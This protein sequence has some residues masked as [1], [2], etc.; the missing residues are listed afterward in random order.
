M[1]QGE[2]IDQETRLR[3]IALSLALELD[4]SLEPDPIV[5]IEHLA[6]EACRD[7]ASARGGIRDLREALREALQ[8]ASTAA[9][10]R[11]RGEF[12]PDEGAR[13]AALKEVLK[14]WED[15]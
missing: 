12:P 2:P 8:I 7:L 13:L 1:S 11:G 5:T 15:Q 4:G 3:A 10:A 9:W 6:S 14:G